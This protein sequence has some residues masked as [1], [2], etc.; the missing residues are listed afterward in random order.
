MRKLISLWSYVYLIFSFFPFFPP[1]LQVGGKW[2]GDAVFLLREILLNRCVDI[3][4]MVSY[5]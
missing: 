3:Q 5:T 4:V 1:S 2:Q